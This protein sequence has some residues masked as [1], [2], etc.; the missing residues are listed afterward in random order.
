MKLR[1]KITFL[2]VVQI[3]FFSGPQIQPIRTTKLCMTTQFIVLISS[4]WLYYISL[5]SGYENLTQ[6][7]D[8]IYVGVST[9][10]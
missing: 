6:G 10:N 1:V 5:L 7:G 8:S 2:V 3:L 9:A 4:T